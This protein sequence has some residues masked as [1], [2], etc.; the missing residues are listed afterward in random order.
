VKAPARPLFLERR[1]YRSRRI[2][3]ASRLLPVLGFLLFLV[4]LVRQPDGNGPTAGYLVYLFSVWFVLIVIAAILSR[5]LRRA[6]GGAPEETPEE[7]P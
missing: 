4:P 7:H 6:T 1:G 3:D 5:R 2:M